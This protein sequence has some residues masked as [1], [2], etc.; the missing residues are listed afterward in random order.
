M[1]HPP[2]SSDLACHDLDYRPLVQAYRLALVREEPAG[3]PV[4]DSGGPVLSEPSAVAGLI[5][6]ML[7][8]RDRE[9]FIALA[10][11]CRHCAIGTH[12]VSIGSLSASIVHPREVFKFA[13][14]ANAASIIVAHNHPSGD[15]TPSRDD[16]DMT[17]RLAE[18]GRVVGID[19][20]DH[21][22]LGDRGWLS[23]KER[24]LL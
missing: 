7:A 4:S 15:T 21:L 17:R 22:I 18:A 16:I 8:G 5:S 6:P 1:P 14:L 11:D 13:I 20:L 3:V 19:V 12:T 2:V 10:L 9:H 23:M 24:R